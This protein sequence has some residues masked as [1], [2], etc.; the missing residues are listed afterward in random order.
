MPVFHNPHSVTASDNSAPRSR[1]EAPARVL[2]Q[3]GQRW[4]ASQDHG[5]LGGERCSVPD[6]LQDALHPAL[7]RPVLIGRTSFGGAAFGLASRVRSITRSTSAR[8][9][10]VGELGQVVAAGRPAGAGD[11]PGTL[12]VEQDLHEE[13]AAGCRA[14]SAT[15]D[16]RTGR[17]SPLRAASSSMATQAYSALALNQHRCP[18]DFIRDQR[19][20]T[21]HPVETPRHSISNRDL[22]NL[23]SR[24]VLHLDDVQ[25]ALL[26][27]LPG[28]PA[29]PVVL[30]R[31]DGPGTR[32]AADARVA[33]VVERVVRHVVVGLRTSTRPSWSSSAAG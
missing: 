12:Q 5:L 16:S 11:Q 20:K 19:L 32:P 25:P 10:S 15:S 3:F 6:A 22:I 2:D 31:P 28:P 8:V 24:P 14:S 27:D 29:G 4:S 17:G 33:V 9:M 1:T 23:K 26:L 30:A 13:P 18:A 7:D 21:R